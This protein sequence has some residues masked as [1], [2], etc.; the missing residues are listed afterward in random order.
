MIVVIIQM[1][2]HLFVHNEH[3]HQIVFVVRKII[4][5]YQPLGIVT[6]MM[7]VAINPMNQKIIVKAK[8]VPVL[9]ICLLVI[10]AIVY[11][12]FISVMETMIVWTILMKMNAINATLANVIRNV[13]LLVLPIK[14]GAV[15][16]VFLND[17][18][19]MV[20]RIV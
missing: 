7:I 20:I 9:V 3:V 18:S 2:V 6:A 19:V 8:N 13:N 17:G 12:E 5:V 4:A 14:T 15:A 1:K 16:N 11:R 10:M